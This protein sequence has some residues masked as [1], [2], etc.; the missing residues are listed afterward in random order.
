[1]SK[2]LLRGL[3]LIEAVGRHGPLTVS[4]LARHT[5]VDVTIVSRTVSACEPEGWLT[6]DRGQITVGPRCALLGL[7]SPV[8]RLIAQAE[9]IVQAIA[10]VTGT[11][12]TA[13]GLVG[14]DVM[15]LASFGNGG[16]DAMPDGLLSRTPLHLLAAG[17]AIAAQL[18]S[19]R[20]AALLPAAPFP[21]PEG[22][23]ASL[24]GSAA[25]PTFLADFTSGDT[26]AAALPAT[27]TELET[28][29]EDIRAAGF[30]RDRGAIHPSVRCIAIPWPTAVL[31][32]SLACS[33]TPEAI[34]GES[35]LIEA[36]LLAA[37]KPGARGLDVAAAAA[38]A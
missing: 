11:A 33:G 32:A 9:P 16:A 30:A 29:L 34:E 38:A 27:A 24:E 8:N 12:V 31:P 4:E 28:E 5:G 17:R 18:P 37:A 3:E 2:T 23:L 22:V 6:K 19:E 26:P 15:I 13:S 20:L 7:A 14:G 1:M 36:C 21:G 35:D 10:G 25:L